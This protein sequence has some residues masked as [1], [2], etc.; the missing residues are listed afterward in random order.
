[1]VRLSTRSH[2]YD[3]FRL[4]ALFLFLKLVVDR[5]CGSGDAYS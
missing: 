5:R 2:E 4:T 3:S 1:M